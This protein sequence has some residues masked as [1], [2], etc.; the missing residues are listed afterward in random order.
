MP[1]IDCLPST[2]KAKLQFD[3]IDFSDIPGQSRLFIDYQTD[4]LKLK[5]Y[6]PSA[7]TSHTEITR[8][9]D[10]VL[11]RYPDHRSKLC[12]VLLSQN[13][14]YGVGA[15]TIENI[16]RLR[17]DRTVAVVTGQQA[18]LFTGPLYSIY[19]ALSAIRM[20]ECLRNRG[21][22]AVP[23][24]WAA[25]EDHDFDEVASAFIVGND[26][27]EIE[28]ALNSSKGNAGRPVGSIAIPESFSREL[29]NVLG[30][31]KLSEEVLDELTAVWKPGRNIGEAF[32]RDL[33]I[34]FR[35]FGL[36][37]VDPL[38]KEIKKLAAPI[39]LQAVNKADEIVD[40]LLARTAELEADGYHAQVLITPDYFPLFYHDDD[41]IRRAVRKDRDAYR[42]VGTRTEFTL[43]EIGRIASDEP[44]RLSPGVMLRPVV[45]DYLFPTAC[46]FGGGAEISYF[47]QNS[48]VYRI[49]ERPSTTILHRQS[50]TV[51]DSKH[52]RIL[53]K[54]DLS[55]PDLFAG[56]EALLPLIV[57]RFVNPTTAR[58]F[59]DAEENIDR[60]LHRLGGELS[61]IDPTLATNLMTRRRKILYHI[62]ALRDKFRRVQVE[63]DEVVS[64]QLR[65]LF[66][67]VLPHGQLQE[68]RLNVAGFASRYGPSFIGSVYNSVDLDERGHRILYL[69]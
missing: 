27:E 61:R 21:V 11:R 52:Q 47:A 22:D 66:T 60:E 38:D 57:D 6:Y 2:S 7:V 68:R 24:F 34:L 62:G 51:L 18:G 1:E 58:T 41:G 9:I 63:R 55:F 12:D 53:R 39:Y 35:D 54:F 44:E 26:G 15:A 64:R 67:S 56:T 3:R 37:V 42:V 40:A 45:Q 28:V 33:Q 32:C 46:Y 19:K 29:S 48:E 65:S 50:L 69:S 49:L 20:V 13:E 30:G 59:A 16:D 17:R 8:H 5:R 25:T 36:I 31:G 23:V 43:D 10:D 14:R 4:P